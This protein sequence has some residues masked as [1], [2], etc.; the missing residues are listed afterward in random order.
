MS[1]GVYLSAKVELVV[2]LI[3]GVII[4]KGAWLEYSK[5]GLLPLGDCR[6]YFPEYYLY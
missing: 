6:L 2:E 5:Y 3:F 4:A 1:I